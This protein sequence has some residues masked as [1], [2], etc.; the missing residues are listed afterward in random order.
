MAVPIR[1]VLVVVFLLVSIVNCS[2]SV[3]PST[4]GLT[5]FQAV[6][7]VTSIMH[8]NNLFP[9]LA[10]SLNSSA[11]LSYDSP[12]FADFKPNT[13]FDAPERANASFVILCRNSDIDGIIQSVRSVEDRFNREYRYPYVFLN[14]EPFDDEFK[15]Y[16]PLTEQVHGLSYPQ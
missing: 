1:Y 4:S 7:F 13:T 16:V 8:K 2:V 11:S 10:P 14:E 12:L 5:T 6:F 3:E 15:R 9:T